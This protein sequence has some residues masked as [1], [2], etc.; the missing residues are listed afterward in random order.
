MMRYG[1]RAAEAFR[2]TTI[3][4]AETLSSQLDSKQAKADVAAAVEFLG[5]RAAPE[6][7]GLAVIGFSLGAYFA[8]DLSVADPDRIRAVVVFYGAG[9][10][11]YSLSRAAYLGHFAEADPYEPAEYV[12]SLEAALRAAGRPVQFYRY[13]GTG[14]WFCEPDRQDAYNHEAATLAWQRTLSFLKESLPSQSH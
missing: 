5:E 3:K 13:Q 1:G 8:L 6:D 7:S 4:E 2:T 12:N 9:P 14:H 11:D 10:G